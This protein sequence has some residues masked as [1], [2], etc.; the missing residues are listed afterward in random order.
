[1]AGITLS[2]Y[3]IVALVRGVALGKTWWVGAFGL[4]C[5]AGG[6]AYLRAPLTRD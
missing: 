4:A 6:V 2:G 3:F 5:I 1:M